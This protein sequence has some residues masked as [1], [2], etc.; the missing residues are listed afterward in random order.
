MEN[1]SIQNDYDSEIFEAIYERILGLEDVQPPTLSEWKSKDVENSPIAF[2]NQFLN[3]GSLEGFD[4]FVLEYD[5]TPHEAIEDQYPNTHREKPFPPII[6]SLLLKEARN[7]PSDEKLEF[8]L[9]ANENIARLAGFDDSDDVPRNTTFWRAYASDSPRIDEEMMEQL[10][11][12]A[13]KIVHHAK[14]VGFELPER[15]EEHLTE[16]GKGDLMNDAEEIAQRLLN[17]TLPHIAFDR[18]QSRT[19]YSPVPFRVDKAPV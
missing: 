18:D 16:F 5:I 10:K 7:L 19:T 17:K 6:W 1:K 14:Y 4:R 3:N 13:R 12:E 8:H 11:I 2:M 15:A 9:K